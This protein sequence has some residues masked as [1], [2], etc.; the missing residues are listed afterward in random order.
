MASRP[1]TRLAPDA[2][3]GDPRARP[4]T[5]RCPQLCRRLSQRDRTRLG[6]HAGACQP[7]LPRRQTRDLPRPACAA[8]R[9]GRRDDPRRPKPAGTPTSHRRDRELACLARS[10]QSDMARDCRAR[11]VHR[12]PR[13]QALFDSAREQIIDAI[14]AD[15]TDTLADDSSSRMALRSWFGLNRAA[16]RSWLRGRPPGHRPRCC[17]P[18]APPP[19]DGRGAGP[20]RPHQQQRRSDH[21]RRQNPHRTKRSATRHPHNAALRMSSA[22]AD[23]RQPDA[24]RL[25]RIPTAKETTVS[26]HRQT[27]L[28]ASS[29]RVAQRAETEGA[30][31]TAAPIDHRLSARELLPVLG[32]DERPSARRSANRAPVHR[33]RGST[34][35]PSVGRPHALTCGC[36]RGSH[37]HGNASAGDSEALRAEREFSIAAREAARCEREVELA[38]S[39]CQVPDGGGEEAARCEVVGWERHPGGHVRRIGDEAAVELVQRISEPVQVGLVPIG[40]DIDV[41]GVVATAVDRMPAPPMTTNC[42][43]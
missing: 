35:G 37:E 39:R 30:P 25:R 42:T 6:G 21:S 28:W 32:R 13:L 4:P 9:A 29:H 24:E 26:P 19:R 8:R 10:Q 22:P 11:R 43:P 23:A 1:R 14:I 38:V 17:S 12:R 18:N 20:Q 41:E 34:P 3:R 36:R 27:V 7:L 16:S 15:Y 5:L 31:G 2:R 33:P 40:G